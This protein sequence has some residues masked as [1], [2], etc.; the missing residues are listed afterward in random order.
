MQES[1]ILEEVEKLENQTKQLKDDIFRIA[2]H[3]RGGVTSEDLFWRYS[4][5]DREILSR[6]IKDNIELTNKTK[7]PFV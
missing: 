5:E 3:M 4:V 7:M 1:D 6:I 2:W